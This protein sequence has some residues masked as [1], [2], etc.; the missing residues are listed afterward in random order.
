MNKYRVGFAA[1]DSEVAAFTPN[2]GKVLACIIVGTLDMK[3]KDEITQAVADLL[4][5]CLIVDVVSLEF[6]SESESKEKPS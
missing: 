5:C 6:V 2:G 4:A 3:R 1:D